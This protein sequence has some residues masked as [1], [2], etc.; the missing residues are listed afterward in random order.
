M[1]KRIPV[2]CVYSSFFF[3]DVLFISYCFSEKKKENKLDVFMLLFLFNE[4]TF[5]NLCQSNIVIAIDQRKSI[6]LVSVVNMNSG[7]M[8]IIF[9]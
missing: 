3:C 4:C 2:F 5:S 7:K 6:C 9:K 8:C 1:R